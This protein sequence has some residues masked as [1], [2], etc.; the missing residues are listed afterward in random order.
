MNTLMGTVHITETVV[1][2][3]G[4]PIILE[5][6]EEERTSKKLRKR[7]LVTTGFATLATVHA[8][9]NIARSLRKRKERNKQLREGEISLKEAHKERVKNN[10]KDVAS[11][12]I[13][14]LTIKNA[15]EEWNEAAKHRQETS[16]FK[17][18]SRYRAQKR[19][20]RRARSL[21]VP[22]PRI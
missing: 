6:T 21:S 3:A 16:S 12:G 17:R 22:P 5:N 13:A 8:G 20:E 9:H 2:V 11:L 14:T 15:I 7:E 18:E 10:V 1:P 19:A 4:V